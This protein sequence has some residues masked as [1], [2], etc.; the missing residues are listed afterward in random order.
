VAGFVKALTMLHMNAD[1]EQEENNSRK[2]RGGS[3]CTNLF[4]SPAEGE[5][6]DY[7]GC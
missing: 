5:Q 4:C 6:A 2:A 3:Y 1:P 7:A